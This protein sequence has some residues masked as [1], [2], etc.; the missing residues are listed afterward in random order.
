VEIAMTAVTRRLGPRLLLAVGASTLAAIP[1]TVLAYASTHGWGPLQHLDNGTANRLHTWAAVHPVVVS[2]LQSVSTIFAPTVLR[3]A[4]AGVIAF[5]LLRKQRRLAAWLATTMVAA[6]LLGYA[7]KDLV[8]RARPKLPDP[9]ASAPGYSFPSGH[10]LNSI[11]FFLVVILLVTPLLSTRGRILSWLV[12]TS[13]VALVGFARVALGVHYVSDVLAGW[14]IGAGLVG[15][16]AAAFESWRRTRGEQPGP[17]LTEGV[18]PDGSLAA[19]G[20]R[21]P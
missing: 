18:D 5:L 12:G 2:F 11:T 21:T 6:G 13:L 15:A 10:A 17:V 3:I 9:V 14:L 19:A 16:T 4:S 7:L 20:E 1:V 8:E